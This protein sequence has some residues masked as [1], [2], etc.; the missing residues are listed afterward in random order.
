MVLLSS[1]SEGSATAERSRLAESAAQMTPQMILSWNRKS[2]KPKAK[3]RCGS[4]SARRFSPCWSSRKEPRGVRS[5][6]PL[7]GRSILS[8]T[9]SGES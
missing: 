1:G 6:V 4:K 5:C 8:V 7:V 3:V 2:V 9:L